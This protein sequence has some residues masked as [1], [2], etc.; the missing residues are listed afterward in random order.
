MA[1]QVD[2]LTVT[3][4]KLVVEYAVRVKPMGQPMLDEAIPLSDPMG[5]APNVRIT[6]QCVP[7]QRTASTF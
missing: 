3:L 6:S 1:R 4:S 2:K 7:R 5:K